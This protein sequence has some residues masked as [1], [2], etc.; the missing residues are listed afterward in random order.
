M[1]AVL[2]R[3]ACGEQMEAPTGAFFVSTIQSDPAGN[4]LPKPYL[5]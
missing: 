5:N 3:Q 4:G 2:C 1:P